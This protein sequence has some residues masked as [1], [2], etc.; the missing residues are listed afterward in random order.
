MGTTIAFPYF[1]GDWSWN[2][3]YD[4][5]PPTANSKWVIVSYKRKYV[6][7]VLVIHLVKLAQKNV[8]LDELTIFDM[9]IAVNWESEHRLKSLKS[10]V[11]K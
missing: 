8:W 5:S 10:W 6:Q 3:F 11:Q 1:C 7:E 4:H 2:T 9:T